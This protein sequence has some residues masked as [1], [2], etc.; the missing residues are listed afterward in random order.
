[1][2]EKHTVLSIIATCSVW[3]IPYQYASPPG[4]KCGLKAGQIE[5]NQRIIDAS[6]NCR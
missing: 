5:V 6:G 1:M 2:L 3:P 4:E